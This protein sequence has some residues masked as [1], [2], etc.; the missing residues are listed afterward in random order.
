MYFSKTPDCL[1]SSAAAGKFQGE[2]GEAAGKEEGGR[3]RRILMT[4]GGGGE[5]GKMIVQMREKFSCHHSNRADQRVRGLL[6]EG[7]RW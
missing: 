2:K 1:A 5:E 4:W 3:E 6:T 7:P